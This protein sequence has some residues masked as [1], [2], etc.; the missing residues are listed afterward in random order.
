MFQELRTSAPD[1]FDGGSAMVERTPDE[2]L[3][4]PSAWIEGAEAWRCNLKGCRIA[5]DV[6]H[7]LLDRCLP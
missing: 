7:G 4:R 1:I 3:E 6:L 5:P 2:A